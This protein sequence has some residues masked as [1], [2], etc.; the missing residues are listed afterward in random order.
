[1]HG[2]MYIKLVEPCWFI[3]LVREQALFHYLISHYFDFLAVRHMN[4]KHMRK[5]LLRV[6]EYYS[7]ERVC[8]CVGIRTK[9]EALK[10]KKNVV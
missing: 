7:D 10:S 8:Y 1:M 4:C 9:I 6:L 2:P 3:L 5:S